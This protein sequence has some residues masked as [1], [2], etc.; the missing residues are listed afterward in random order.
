MENSFCL[1]FLIFC[2]FLLFRRGNGVY[3]IKPDK[4]NIRADLDRTDQKSRSAI[5]RKE[6]V[7]FWYVEIEFFNIEVEV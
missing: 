3:E 2:L 5:A 6:P 7:V 1:F 4:S